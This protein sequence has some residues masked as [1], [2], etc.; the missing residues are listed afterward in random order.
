M[1]RNHDVWPHGREKQ[2]V[3][4]TGDTPEERDEGERARKLQTSNEVEG[5]CCGADEEAAEGADKRLAIGKAWPQ[6]P[7]LDANR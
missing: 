2:G 5:S 4:Q 6:L 1:P 7:K 3:K